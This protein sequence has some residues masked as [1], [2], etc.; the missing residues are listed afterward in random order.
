M[1]Q[2]F[3]NNISLETFAAITA[4]STT[5]AFT[6]SP[7]LPN[8]SAAGSFLLFT[9]SDGTNTEIVKVNTNPTLGAYTIIR[10]HEGTTA[11]SWPAGTSAELRLTAAPLNDLTDVMES[12]N[13]RFIK[14]PSQHQ[15]VIYEYIGGTTRESIIPGGGTST[16]AQA[17][18]EDTARVLYGEPSS[19][20]G[21]I[22]TKV[23]VDLNLQGS[24]SSTSYSSNSVLAYNTELQLYKPNTYSRPYIGE[25]TRIPSYEV[26]FATRAYYVTGDVRHALF[27]GLYVTNTTTFVSG[28]P[29]EFINHSFYRE[30]E[31]RT[32]FFASAYAGSA[33]SANSSSFSLYADIFK[34][35][36][37]GGYK[38]FTRFSDLNRFFGQ[39]T[40]YHNNAVVFH[41][42][43]TNFEID[44]KVKVGKR[45]SSSW[46]APFY[47]RNDSPGIFIERTYHDS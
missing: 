6:T 25:A 31:N 36:S 28:I 13:E 15:S 26:E 38:S 1:P 44:Y 11:Q 10:G 40:T 42:G 32:Y 27:N 30:S 19:A 12:Y 9:L 20:S 39:Y 14:Y 46:N 5:L 22:S 33:L 35:V 37:N 45:S 18:D 41:L 47:V 21:R 23:V 4:T 29:F 24:G 16:T 34:G 7:S 8:L 3:A 2:K 43:N 17:Q